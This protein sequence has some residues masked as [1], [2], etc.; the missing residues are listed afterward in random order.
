M[1]VAITSVC[2]VIWQTGA[3]C[4][5]EQVSVFVAI[6]SVCTVIWQTGASCVQE[7]V[8]TEAFYENMAHMLRYH[9]Q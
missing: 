3:S 1:F 7:Q 2:T 5:Q 4:V 8:V 9:R 6:T